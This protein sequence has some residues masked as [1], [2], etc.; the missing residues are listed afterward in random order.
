[1]H[2][3]AA[4][5]CV[6]DDFTCCIHIVAATDLAMQPV[7]TVLFPWAC[8][9]RVFDN[10]GHHCELRRFCPD[11]P[12]RNAIAVVLERHECWEC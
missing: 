1:M 6:I 11:A 3:S 10:R 8:P 4:A 9:R 12:G 7:D 5:L 2:A